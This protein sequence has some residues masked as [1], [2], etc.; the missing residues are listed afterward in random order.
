MTV[1]ELRKNIEHLAEPELKEFSKWFDEYIADLWDAQIE[2]DAAAGKFDKL[3]EE[4][5]ASYEAGKCT[6]L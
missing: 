4:A 1:E 6:E 3:A 5:V 2:R